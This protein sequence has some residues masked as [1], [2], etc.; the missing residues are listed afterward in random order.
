MPDRWLVLT[1][2][3][4]SEELMEE[5]A[6]GLIAL[7]GS[8]VEEDVDLLTTYVPEP[9]E[10]ERFLRTAA[11]RLTEI[12]GGEPEV[13]WS[14]KDDQDW[15]RHWRE[16]LGPRRVSPRIVITQPWNPVEPGTGD[17]VV[18]V[19]PGSAFGTGE[20]ATTRGVLRLMEG[21]VHDG[22]RVLDVGTGSGIL[23]I[24]A[25]GLGAGSVLAVDSD[26]S[27]LD[28]ARE[29][30]ERNGM[31][32]RV[33]LVHAAVDTAFLGGVREGGFD[34]IVAN[35]LSGVLVPL[36]PGFRDAL[37]PTGCVILSGILATESVAVVAAADEAGLEPAGEDREDEWWSGRFR[38]SRFPGGRSASGRPLAPAR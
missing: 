10:P 22:A 30:L 34:L 28:N 38:F 16:G 20:H 21:C 1:V 13:V 15:S 25:A 24:A 27:A 6:E 11:D 35:V 23:A 37:V 9:A 26:A 8:A 5:L 4:P 2:R 17:V 18:V 14:W 7:G 12:A 19:D 31:A 32:D 3:V 29:N 36:L 33:E